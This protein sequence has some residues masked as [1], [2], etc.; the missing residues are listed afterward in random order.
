VSLQINTS[1]YAGAGNQVKELMSKGES[2]KG[3]MEWWREGADKARVA[4]MDPIVV[5]DVPNPD[6]LMNI[7]G[8]QF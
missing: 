2:D 1:S 8:Y 4:N 3:F 7:T 5:E 6:A